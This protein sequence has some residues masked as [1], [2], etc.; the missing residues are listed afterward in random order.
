[1]ANFF[2][3]C[4]ITSVESQFTQLVSCWAVHNLTKWKFTM[5]DVSYKKWERRRLT[6]WLFQDDLEV[7]N[8]DQSK[9]R[10][11]GDQKPGGGS[12]NKNILKEF[13]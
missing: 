7:R 9:A 8:N 2:V 1:M 13:I 10:I 5:R 4:F 11:I 6:I 3:Q 12:A